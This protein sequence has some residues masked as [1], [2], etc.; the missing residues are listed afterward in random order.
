MQLDSGTLGPLREM[1]QHPATAVC[2]SNRGEQRG[3]TFLQLQMEEALLHRGDRAIIYSRVRRKG[4]CIQIN[5]EQGCYIQLDQGH[6][7]S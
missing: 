4:Y 1:P 3:E 6:R 5:E 7:F 2:L